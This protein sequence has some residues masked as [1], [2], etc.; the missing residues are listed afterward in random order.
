VAI[1][2][3][4]EAL[5]DGRRGYLAAIK[6]LRRRGL[7]SGQF[8]PINDEERALVKR[9]EVL[10]KAAELVSGD[11]DR[12]YGSW[13]QNSEAIAKGWSVIIGHDVEP[14]HVAL[15]MDWVKTVRLIPGNHKDSWVDKAGYS[16]LGAE[17]DDG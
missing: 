9:A 7:L 4:S 17:Y 12:D 10:L 3:K 8:K 11:R 2:S 15:M 16:A 1:L 13:E 14:R 5:Q 6:I